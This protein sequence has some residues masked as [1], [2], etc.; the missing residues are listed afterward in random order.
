MEE[1]KKKYKKLI[2]LFLSIYYRGTTAFNFV[3]LFK[4]RALNLKYQSNQKK[5]ISLNYIQ[6]LYY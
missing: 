6:K 2:T 4:T 1:Q 3:N 5:C